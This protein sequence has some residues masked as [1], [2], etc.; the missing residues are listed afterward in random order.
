MSVLLAAGVLV[1]LALGIWLGA[2]FDRL[3][4]ALEG[5]RAAGPMAPLRDWAALLIR[6]QA[7]TEAPDR[8]NRLLAPAWYL[9]LAA[10]GLSV[11]P[12]AEGLALWHSPVGIVVW[13][14]CEA[15][16]VITVFL[17]GWSPN[18]P[19]PLIGAY[20]YAAIGLPV[21]LPSMFV[22][23]AAALPAE[24]LSLIAIV[25]SQ[26]D[27]WNL[28]RQPLG[29]PLFL[30]VG[31]TLTLRGPLDFAGGVDI[32]GGTSAEESGAGLFL[33][34]VARLATLVAFS[35]LAAAVF[36][37][38]PL[39]PLLPGPVWL[40]LKTALVM[41]LTVL[42]GRLIARTTPSRMLHVLWVWLLPLS[43]AHLAVSGMVAL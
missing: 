8:M 39:G 17:H 10:I 13:G 11:V 9:A 36:L 27:S 34:Q 6:D 31:L 25:D 1:A 37:G 22:L 35:A 26:R 18:A 29:L 30:V 7:E 4:P 15:L 42:A 33:W 38:G 5:G 40:A 14:S 19:F 3:A 12:V 20:R 43:F 16:I 28:V 24:S 2:W 21:M 32:A 41:A 23:I